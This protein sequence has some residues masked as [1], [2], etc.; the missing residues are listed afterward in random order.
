M[1]AASTPTTASHP[2][3]ARGLADRSPV[4]LVVI[5]VVLFSVGPV[6]VGGASIS[7]PVFAFWRLWLGTAVLAVIAGVHLAVTGRR[8][9]RRG[10]AWAVACGLAFAG[11]QLLLMSAL[12]TT[13]VVDVTLMNTLAPVVVAVL[14]LPLFGE[15]PG[16]AFR[17]WSA[18][19]I[20]GAALVVMAG[21]SG[22]DGNPLGMALA[23]GNVVFYALFFVGSKQGRDHIDT[24]PFLFGMTAV[25]ALVVSA[26]VLLTGEAITPISPHDVALCLGVAVLPGIVGHFCVTWPLQRV[27]ANL[28]PV[29]M[30]GIPVLSGLQAWLWLG[31]SVTVAVVLG[32][33]LTLAGVAGA[34]RAAAGPLAVESL[35]T[36]EES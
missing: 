18:V 3:G 7:G 10:A 17:L 25:A 31:Q 24:I 28:P 22:P 16:R 30:L 34:V 33:L 20:A 36:A 19:A 8:V 5:G 13:S 27:P 29:L 14:A 26:F 21:S 12:K 23:A 4:A 32:G 1:T 15:R 2:T 11:H 9:G 35:A 6:L